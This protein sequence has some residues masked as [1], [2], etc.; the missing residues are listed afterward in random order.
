M[1]SSEERLYAEELEFSYE[2]AGLFPVSEIL[3]DLSFRMNFFC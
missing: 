3:N 1:A 2:K